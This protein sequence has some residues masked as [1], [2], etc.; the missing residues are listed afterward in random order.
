[1]T[2]ETE[3]TREQLKAEADALAREVLGVSADE[4]WRRVRQEHLHEGTFFA[5]RLAEIFFLLGEPPQNDS[6]PY[7]TAAE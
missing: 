4:A 3:I 6:H 2:N 7:R 5:V 1:M